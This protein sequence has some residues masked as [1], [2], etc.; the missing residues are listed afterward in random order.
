MRFTK[1]LVQ[2][3]MAFLSYNRQGNPG[4]GSST[5]DFERLN[6]GALTVGLL[7]L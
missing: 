4:G 3:K 5:R 2:A 7:S 6:E 1:Q